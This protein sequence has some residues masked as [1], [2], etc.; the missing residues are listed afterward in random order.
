[1]RE[2]DLLRRRE[3]EGVEKT[4]EMQNQGKKAR[5]Y[6]IRGSAGQVNW[7]NCCEEEVTGGTG[8][9][10]GRNQRTPIIVCRKVRGAK[11]TLF[12][13]KRH[14]AYKMERKEK[15]SPRLCL[16]RRSPGKRKEYRRAGKEGTRLRRKRGKDYENCE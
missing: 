5:R 8:N 11:A 7:L 13:E 9:R 6:S 3:L 10:K 4:S 16:E 1:L 12:R 14:T 2:G 15:K